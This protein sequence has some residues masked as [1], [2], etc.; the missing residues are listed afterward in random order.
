M[1]VEERHTFDRCYLLLYT[2]DIEVVIVFYCTVRELEI[3]AVE[4]L[5]LEFGNTGLLVVIRLD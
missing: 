2:G 4:F 3:R 1:V 5:E